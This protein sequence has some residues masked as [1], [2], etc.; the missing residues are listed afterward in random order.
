M[1][2]GEWGPTTIQSYPLIRYIFTSL[3][4]PM[5]EVALLWVVPVSV[6]YMYKHE[7]MIIQLLI[8]VISI[9]FEI[10]MLR[11]MCTLK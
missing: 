1:T 3:F 10:D 6:I 9:K 7:E 8:S 4:P 11:K 5:I 2:P